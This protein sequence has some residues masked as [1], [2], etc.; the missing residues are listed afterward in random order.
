[1]RKYKYIIGNSARVKHIYFFSV[2]WIN[3]CPQLITIG[4]FNCST[5]FLTTPLS[6]YKIILFL[7]SP[8]YQSIEVYIIYK[9]D[10]STT[11]V[12]TYINIP[13]SSCTLASEFSLFI[14]HPYLNFYMVGKYPRVNFFPD[15]VLWDFAWFRRTT[16]WSA[17]VSGYPPSNCRL[18]YSALF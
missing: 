4:S 6:K 2:N 17:P 15:W 5:F 16:D 8:P 13:P 14:Q 18:S 1:M 12:I 7:P 11:S 3:D 10:A 9:H